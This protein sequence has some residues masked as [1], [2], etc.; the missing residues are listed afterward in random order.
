MEGINKGKG[1]PLD[2]PQVVLSLCTKR[3]TD[4]RRTRVGERR[5]RTLRKCRPPRIAS[6]RTART[7][8]EIFA[9]LETDKKEKRRWEKELHI[10]VYFLLNS[11]CPGRS[12]TGIA[13][14]VVK[15]WISL[16]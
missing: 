14:F 4:E 7:L 3:V 13:M 2:L 5:K 9:K 15:L 8:T 1:P 11:K 12:G 10:E 16:G 6:A